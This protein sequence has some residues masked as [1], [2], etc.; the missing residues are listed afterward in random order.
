[1]GWGAGGGGGAGG[2]GGGGGVGVRGVGG[3]GWWGG[4][5]VGRGVA[6]GVVARGRMWS[7]KAVRSAFPCSPATDSGWNC[8]PQRGRLRCS[9][10][11]T[12]LSSAQAVARRVVGRGSWTAREWWRTAVKCW[13]SPVNRLWSVWWMWERWP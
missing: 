4:G 1:G 10:P 6:G 13:G 7:K 11:M 3:G 8:R 12:T 5:G 9:R 2:W